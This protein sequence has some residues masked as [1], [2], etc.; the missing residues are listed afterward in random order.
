[1]INGLS[2]SWKMRKRSGRNGW[3]EWLQRSIKTAICPKYWRIFPDNRELVIFGWKTEN[4]F[5]SCS[6]LT[7]LL[8]FAPSASKQP[9]PFEPSLPAKLELA[10]Q[11]LKT[12]AMKTKLLICLLFSAFSVLL[13]CTAQLNRWGFFLPSCILWSFYSFFIPLFR[14][15]SNRIKGDTV[16]R[17]ELMLARWVKEW[18]HC[19]ICRDV[20]QIVI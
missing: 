7:S 9:S 5:G 6:N 16:I 14:F 2:L 12:K 1:M 19:Y 10:S 17:S 4:A 13:C 15:F 3:S 8:C 18:H 11:A 20:F